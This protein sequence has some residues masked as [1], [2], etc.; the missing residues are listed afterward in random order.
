MADILVEWRGPFDYGPQVT[1]F[2]SDV[3]RTW[4]LNDAGEGSLFLPDS[5][6]NLNQIV[7]WGNLLRI[8]ERDVPPWAG[9]ILERAWENGGVRLSLK[10]AEALLQKKITRQ[11][12]I[13]GQTAATAAGAIAREVFRSAY[14]NNNPFQT[15]KA[16]LFDATKTHFKQYDYVDCFETLQALAEEDGAAFW[17]DPTDLTVNFRDRR[18]SETSVVLYENVH[19][20]DVRVVEQAT[21]IVTA[22]LAL[23]EGSDLPSKPKITMQWWTVAEYFAAEVLNVNGATYPEALIE[24]AKERIRQQALPRTVIDANFAKVDA[25][26]G[27]FHI[28]DTIELVTARAYDTFFVRG[29]KARVKVVGLEKGEAD[30]Y[31]CVFEFVP[32]QTINQYTGWQLS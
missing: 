15:L 27:A 8:Y 30:S 26:W 2:A 12:L 6:D 21:D 5:V 13:F 20:F 24:P 1:P 28:G 31:R 9:I 25:T 4:V 14:Q 19:L 32:W 23:G 22:V 18:G 17:V 3:S 11:G 7:K 10:S 29:S 16:G